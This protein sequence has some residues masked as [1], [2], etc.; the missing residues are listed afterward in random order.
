ML[1][2]GLDAM[3]SDVDVVWLASPWPLVRY[4]DAKER[5]RDGETPPSAR[6][7]ALSDVILSVDQPQSRPEHS[8]VEQVQQYMDSHGYHWHVGSELNTGIAFF[9][10]SA[11][12]RAVLEEWAQRM[13][14][15]IAKGD[16]NHDQYWLNLVLQP[17]V[18]TDLKKDASARARWLPG[19]LKAAHSLGYKPVG[20][21]LTP[22]AFE[23][24][25]PVNSSFV[26]GAFQFKR[27][28][29]GDSTEVVLSTFP[30]AQFSNGHTFFVQK[31]HEIVRVP[32]IAVHTT[33]Q[34]GDSAVYAYGKRQRLRDEKLWFMDPPEYYNGSYLH[35]ITSP[36][37]MLTPE[38]SEMLA[39]ELGSTGHCLLDHL[40]LSSLQRQ[41][42]QDAFLL[43]AA[44]GRTL[45]LPQIWCVADRFWTILNHCLIGS[46]VEMPQP[47]VCPL[48]H[49]YNLPIMHQSGLDW[50]EHSFLSNPRVP[51][52][53]ASS[54]MR[55]RVAPPDGAASAEPRGGT[56]EPELT[57][58][59][60]SDFAQ[61]ARAVRESQSAS[62]D[63]AKH[64]VG[65][66]VDDL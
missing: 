20:L 46:K 3:V 50:R 2:A 25:L 19:V 36:A 47:F 41:W 40:R 66:A 39:E 6:L 4:G 11:G 28:F 53:V 42:I 32:P 16:P 24:Q 54:R 14:D 64:S 65:F 21:P 23:K 27:R 35:L 43:A 45:V 55:L 17:R 13:K 44:M 9:R 56:S 63:T 52:E 30:I 51:P 5:A 7:L 22:S 1:A 10:N 38:R 29:D 49:S 34:Y 61:L 8:L 59:A 37:Q 58:P 12:A 18:L 62:E 57:I 33:Y 31:L 60:G 15:A 26:R 48:D